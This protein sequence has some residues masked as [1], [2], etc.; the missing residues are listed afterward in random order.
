MKSIYFQIQ[1]DLEHRPLL[2]GLIGLICGIALH[3]FPVVIA[4]LVAAGWLSRKTSA[5]A[6][7]GLFFLL[8]LFLTPPVPFTGAE[9]DTA[10]GT[11]YV[12][13]VPSETH[14][15]FVFD[16]K[17]GQSRL[18][19]FWK[20]DQPP[21]FG[22]AVQVNGQINPVKQSP[23]AAALE[24][25]SGTVALDP[26]NCSV[27]PAGNELNRFEFEF[28]ANLRA[29]IA[30]DIG[31]REG[32]LM[33]GLA[34]N[35]SAYLSAQ[36]K[37]ELENTGTQ[38]LIAASG[39]HLFVFETLFMALFIKQLVPRPARLV[40][41]GIFLLFY[42]GA[43]GY[44]AATVRAGIMTMLAAS[45]YLWNRQYD[46]LSALSLAGIA[47]LL[48]QPANLFTPGFQ[49]SMLAV[50]ILILGHDAWQH[51]KL[52]WATTSFWGW[53]GST[54]VGAL[55]FKVVAWTGPI[56]CLIPVLLLGPAVALCLA[57][58]GLHAISPSLAAPLSLLVKWMAALIWKWLDFFTSLRFSS[59]QL[60]KVSGYWLF[61]FYGGLALWLR[62]M[63]RK[64]ES[65]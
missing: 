16:L 20:G 62:T 25:I 24:G 37:T 35:D 7:L 34:F 53:L 41:F 3:G 27:V 40:L 54:P 39:L 6:W 56:A 17:Q 19:G 1:G 60:T 8:G 61:L 57:D 12:T 59:A 33:A 5:L 65:A 26:Q 9:A 2:A 36:D 46:G 32:A 50:F 15:G 28:G 13:S 47:Y 14:N 29:F 31:G 22:D 45:A 64:E 38:F 21:V 42:I 58:Y 11:Y 30:R 49:L 52:E 55:W 43:T 4:V 18:I 48:W 44:H 10:N 23:E 63:K 51:K